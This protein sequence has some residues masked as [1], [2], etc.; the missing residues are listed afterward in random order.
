M[1]NLINKVWFAGDSIT[2][3]YGC[4]PGK[5]SEYYNYTNG[6][7]KR[8]WT[9][10]IAEYLN[11]EQKNIATI[12]GSSPSIINSIIKNLKNFK[13]SSGP[14]VIPANRLSVFAS[15]CTL[16]HQNVF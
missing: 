13:K 2:Y 3:G 6:N 8:R 5:G 10:I 12:A 11:L 7:H 9:D 16:P 15:S 1:P 14:N 4:R